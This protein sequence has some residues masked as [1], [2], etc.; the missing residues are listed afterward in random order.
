MVTIR[1]KASAPAY[2]DDFGFL[3][4]HDTSGYDYFGAQTIAY[5]H[6][7]KSSVDEYFERRKPLSERNNSPTMGEPAVSGTVQVGQTLT[8]TTRDIL[9][10][11]GLTGVVY[12]YQWYRHDFATGLKDFIG[13]EGATG[14]TYTVTD[15]EACLGIVVDVIFTDDAGYRQRLSSFPVPV[16]PEGQAGCPNN[17]ATGGPDISGTAR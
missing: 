10:I 3:I 6:T 5:L 14:P 4:E 15:A 13:G 9:D 11:D 1:R 7:W 16:P 12:G 8:A 17:P 2:I